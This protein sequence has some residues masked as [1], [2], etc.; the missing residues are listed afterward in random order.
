MRG[1]ALLSPTALVMAVGILVPTSILLAMSFWS[2]QGL[3]FDTTLTTANYARAAS[4]PIFGD[5][6]MR[7]FWISAWR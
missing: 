6:L 3:D 1:W 5:F 4:E 2:R 7:S